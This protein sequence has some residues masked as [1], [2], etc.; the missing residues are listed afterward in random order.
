MASSGQGKTF[1]TG[2]RKWFQSFRYN[3][4]ENLPIF[5]LDY[6]PTSKKEEIDGNYSELGESLD[7]QNKSVTINGI[8]V[9]F[10]D[11]KHVK[12]TAFLRH[13]P[14]FFLL[15]QD[16]LKTNHTNRIISQIYSLGENRIISVKKETYHDAADLTFLYNKEFLRVTVD[17]PGSV[18]SLRSKCEN[19][20]GVIEWREADVLY[21]HR[22]AIDHNVRVGTWYQAEIRGGEIQKLTLIKNRT[23]PELRIIAYDIE[24]VF[25]QTREP[26]P[27]RDAISMISLFTGEEN[28]LL[29]NDKVVDTREITKIDIILRKED[30]DHIKPWVDY[31]KAGTVFP[32]SAIYERIPVDV[33]I[34]KTEKQLLFKFY[35][36]IEEF[37]P[38]VVA[39]FFGDKFDIPFLAI[40]SRLYDIS[41]EK[42]TGF[43]IEYKF[44]PG[45]TNKEDMDIRENFSPA[46]IDYVAGGG[47]IHLDAYLFNEKYSYL[48][49]K[50]LGLK[51]SVEKKLK[52]IPIGRQALFAINEN[53]ADAVGYAACDGYITLR[54]VKEIVLDFFISMGQMFPVPSS[55]LL[56]RRSG[57]L[58]DLLIDAEN[59]KFNIVGRR[60]VEQRN[61]KSF[62]PRI[63]IDSFAY[64]GG[65]VE[66]RHSGVFRSDILKEFMIN[67]DALTELKPLI[68]EVIIQESKKSTKAEMKAEFERKLLEEFSDLSIVFSE[69]LDRLINDFNAIMQK[70]DLS[71]SEFENNKVKFRRIL[72]EISQIRAEGVDQVVQQTLTQIDQLIQTKEAVQMRGV[73]VDVTSM[74]PS[75]I[76]QYKLQ[77]SGI[78]PLSKCKSCEYAESDGSCYFEGDWVIKLTARRPCR[79]RQQ[80]STKCDPNICSPDKESTCSNYEPEQGTSGRIQE[81]FV[82]NNGTTDVYKLRKKAGLVK[83]P[84]NKSYLGQSLGSVDLYD[85]VRTWLENSVEATQI[86]SRLNRNYFDIFEDQPSNL[87]LPENTYMSLDVR[88]KKI[89]VLLSVNSRV[90]QKSFNFVARIM[91]DFYNTRVKHKTEAQ[92][93]KQIIKQKI[94]QNQPVPAEMYRQQKFHDSTQLGMK[95][96]LNSVYGLLGM[97]GGVRNAS[98]PCAG[99]TTKLSADLIRWTADQLE[100]IGTVTELDT[101]GIWL[102]MPRQFPL[103]F[104]VNL[105][106]PMNTDSS[107][108]VRVTIIDKILNE[109]VK[110][111]GFRNDNYWYNDGSQITKIG[112]SLIGFEQDGPYDFMFVMGKKKYIVYNYHSKDKTWEEK[113]LTGLESKRADFSKLQKYY[114]EEIINSYLENFDPDHPISL[115]EIYQNALKVSDRIKKEISSGKLDHTY[116]IKPKAIN[117][118]LHEYKSKL[119]QVK[120]AYILQDLGYTIEPGIRIQMVNIKGNTVIPAQVFD[121]D[122]KTVKSVFIKHGISTLSFMLNEI[123]SIDDIRNLIDTK[124]YLKDV[125]GPGRIFERMIQYPMETQ[126]I[127]A[128]SQQVLTVDE[129]PTQPLH[130]NKEKSHSKTSGSQIATQPQ[131]NITRQ[132]TPPRKVEIIRS[133]VGKGK[134]RKSKRQ[135]RKLKAQSLD[136][137]FNFPTLEKPTSQITKTKTKK[138]KR[139]RQKPP[140]EKKP[141]IITPEIEPQET[142]NLEPPIIST[143]EINELETTETYTNGRKPEG[144]TDFLQNEKDSDQDIICSQCGAIVTSDEILDDGCIYCS[145]P[146]F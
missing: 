95:V 141:S 53:P 37:K 124:Q 120:A 119:P 132:K 117:K 42:R 129:I 105:V 134:I 112:K 135:E 137:I 110:S 85:R 60:R 102:W 94:S 121:F 122:F 67:K 2:Y 55:E 36:I 130:K 138:Q 50:D 71:Q 72:E 82:R 78:V 57:S 62:S 18:P 86:T 48:P 92:R 99:I 16:G 131:S 80:G 4:S 125:Y 116:F 109:K 54:Y 104:P 106:N 89:T 140:Q 133:K 66:A 127:K 22:V 34:Y 108:V 14:Y 93:L 75:Q 142:M 5:I 1:L 19:V 91:D 40:R 35:E 87:H 49:K 114:Q 63:H 29:I 27:N 115:A 64:T 13:A 65:L 32:E 25:D 103:D 139:S 128:D 24:T 59:H 44:E 23:P 15:L 20:E 58:D 101:D 30:K 145:D 143:E 68:R 46:K 21:H 8:K 81:I 74:Y 73:H 113:E 136:T 126:Q 118:G 76:R 56:T 146:T 12:R 9:Y 100:K 47:V 97:K 96:P 107:R 77:P 51:P 41:L 33:Q 111:A 43:R 79:H 45:K 144:S 10:L 90:C 28:Y 17:H 6:E 88:T 7:Y 39:D 84:I 69:D 61:I 11:D 70:Y 83:I 3:Q 123:T 52:I 98:T 38:D 26:N 31:C